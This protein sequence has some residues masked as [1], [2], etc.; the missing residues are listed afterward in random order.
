MTDS[1]VGTTKPVSCSK[2]HCG[3]LTFQILIDK[4]WEQSKK[5]KAESV[6]HS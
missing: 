4:A 1:S 5:L 2:E 3:S 6:C